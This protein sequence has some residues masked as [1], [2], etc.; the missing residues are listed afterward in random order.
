[1]NKQSPARQKVTGT[2][3]S[4]VAR[5]KS[6]RTFAL[7]ARATVTGRPDFI[8]DD[9]MLGSGRKTISIA[10]SVAQFGAYEYRVI[11]ITLD[12]GIHTGNYTFSASEPGLILA[13]SYVEYAVVGGNEIY[14][15]CEGLT[16]SL[17]IEFTGS[18]IKLQ[19]FS[20][21]AL[22]SEG[23]E[24]TVTGTLDVSSTLCDCA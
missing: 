14:Y 10:A 11:N 12:L 20:F 18:H 1:M 3:K 19:A 23:K 4:S 5:K 15:N 24:L 17:E 13:M 9:I 2:L 22:D 21:T 7:E 8:A 16:G 6:T